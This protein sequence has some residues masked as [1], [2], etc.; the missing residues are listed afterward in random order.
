MQ[1]GADFSGLKGRPDRKLSAVVR[2]ALV[3]SPCPPA[4]TANPT[5]GQSVLL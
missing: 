3:A 4:P 2:T 5:S 1:D